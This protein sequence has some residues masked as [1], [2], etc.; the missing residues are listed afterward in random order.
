MKISDIKKRKYEGYIWYS[1]KQEPQILHGVEFDF[2][3]VGEE[4][5]PFI[6][7]ALLFA[8]DENVS[9]TIRHTGSYLIK[10]FDMNKLPEGAELVEITY[11]PHRQEK[12]KKLGF[13][14]L[15]LPELD[16][17]CENMP[18]LK[19]KALLFTGFAN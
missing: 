14:Q 2:A 6:V 12:K 9:I 10:E 8:P 15:W 5:N 1:D 11:L 17:F 19:M 16:E 4:D 7:E 3:G 13:K 18:V